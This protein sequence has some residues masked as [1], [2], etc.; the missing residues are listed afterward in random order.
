MITAPSISLRNRRLK[1]TFESLYPGIRYWPRFRAAT[2]LESKL[3][4]PG[5]L[6]GRDYGESL[7]N[8]FGKSYEKMVDSDIARQTL[9]LD[10]KALDIYPNTYY[11]TLS[12]KIGV[13]LDNAVSSVDSSSVPV[14]EEIS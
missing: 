6:P 1:G 14:L 11:D 10:A 13:V 9:G 7:E 4:A 2:K 5:P 12:V 3:S 8:T